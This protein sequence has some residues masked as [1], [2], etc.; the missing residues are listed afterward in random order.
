MQL[1][2]SDVSE[3]RDWGISGRH[4]PAVRQ[5][6]SA[7]NLGEQAMRKGCFG[8]RG[9]VIATVVAVGVAVPIPH[10]VLAQTPETRLETIVVT[11]RKREESLQE[12]PISIAV[13]TADAMERLGV[14]N[15]NDLGDFTPNLLTTAGQVATTDANFFVRGIGQFDYFSSVDPGV[16]LYVD[17]VYFARMTGGNLDVSDVDRIEVLRGPQGT[18]FGRNAIGGAVSVILKEPTSE[19]EGRVK[20]GAGER[21]RRMFEGSVNLPIVDDKLLSRFSFAYRQQDGYGERF[22]D[23]ATHFDIDDK[24]AR[25]QLLWLVTE[26][27]RVKFTGDVTDSQ[28]TGP[29]VINRGLNVTPSPLGVPMPADINDDLSSD[30]LLSF[31]NLA[32]LQEVD[33]WGIGMTIDWSITENTMIKSISAVRDVEQLLTLDNDATGYAFY[34]LLAPTDQNQFSQELQLS[35]ASNDDFWNGI[36]GLYYFEEE[37]DQTNGI[38]LGSVPVRLDPT[39]LRLDQ[40]ILPEIV[41]YAVYTQ[42]TFK[43]TD[44]MSVTA[45]IRASYEKKEITYDFTLDNT[46]GLSPFFPPVNLQLLPLTT[47]DEEWNSVTPRVGIEFQAREGTLL[48]ASYAEGFRSGGFNGR[49]TSPQSITPYDPEDSK[50]Y[51]VGLKADLLDNRLRTNLAIF[52]NDYQKIQLTNF[53]DGFITVDNAGDAELKGFELEVTTTPID[54]LLLKVGIGYLDSKYS[55]LSPGAGGGLITLDTPLPYAPE[56]NAYLG[57]EYTVSL[58][59]AGELGLR[60][61]YVYVDDINFQPAGLPGDRQESYAVTNVRLTY[62]DPSHKWT[63][64]LYGKNMFDEEYDLIRFDLTNPGNVGVSTFYPAAP[65]EYGVDIGYSW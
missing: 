24:A 44:R 9:L 42:H 54:D 23:D 11:A 51:E 12:T 57:A 17:G 15:V 39:C 64:A 46:A 36:F 65:R 47:V 1:T 25:G 34:D 41:S 2:P 27:L 49:P 4:E 52:Y 31:S 29:A 19:F 55:S 38:C 22:Y 26:N 30:R 18:L 10:A 53:S 40:N 7:S 21:S 6:M 50:V 43:V 48:Y 13:F 63:V 37:V 28:G 8:P 32:P 5:V 45:G 16:A 60:G 35:M 58:G 61:D 59:S 62:E 3:R 33:S 14:L 20:L 56:W